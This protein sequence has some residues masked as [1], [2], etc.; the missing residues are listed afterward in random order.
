MPYHTQL[1][2]LMARTSRLYKAE[3]NALLARKN[4]NLSS[5][6]CG[7][8]VLLWEEDHKNQQELADLLKKDKGGIT[9]IIKSLQSRNLLKSIKDKED[10]RVNKIVLTDEGRALRV[11]LEP[12]IQELRRKALLHISPEQ[13]EKTKA[14]LYQIITNLENQQES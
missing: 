13:Q 9:R 6:M 11:D 5:E 12:I 10:L 4:F 14:I 7:M 3:L 2:G 1:T 8:L